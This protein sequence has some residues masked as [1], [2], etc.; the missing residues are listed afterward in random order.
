MHKFSQAP[1]TSRNHDVRTC[2]LCPVCLLS[3]AKVA[4]SRDS[5][6]CRPVRGSVNA[7]SKLTQSPHLGG[8]SLTS[9]GVLIPSAGTGLNPGSA[10]HCTAGIRLISSKAAGRHLCTEEDVLM[11]RSSEAWDTLGA[12]RVSTCASPLASHG[13]GPFWTVCAAS[14]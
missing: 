2:R 14:S 3:K 9:A 12:L 1:A 8:P 5:P 4:P 13:T 6:C 10:S 7:A 11:A